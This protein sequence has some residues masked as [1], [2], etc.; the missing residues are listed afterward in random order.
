MSSIL[1]QPLA[2]LM[3]PSASRRPSVRAPTQRISAVQNS[4]KLKK[5][6]AKP[7][8][9]TCCNLSRLETVVL[10]SLVPAAVTLGGPC[11]MLHELLSGQTLMANRHGIFD[12]VQYFKLCP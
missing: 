12:V 8:G 10:P 1:Q 3:P 2:W 11:M 5:T 9:R 7:S 4:A 6:L